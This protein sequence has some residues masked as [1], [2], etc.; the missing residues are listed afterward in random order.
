MKDR[1]FTLLLVLLFWSGCAIKPD[2]PAASTGN[3]VPAPIAAP[4]ATPSSRVIEFKNGMVLVGVVEKEA[5]G[6]LDI[7]SDLLGPVVVDAS[8]QGRAA[9]PIEKARLIV[10]KNGSRLVGTIQKQEGGKLYID[11]E[12]LGLVVIDADHVSR[13]PR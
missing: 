9:R 10:L 1:R 7:R 2:T 13:R 6:K 11:A 3:T 12:I 8:A 5:G 4:V